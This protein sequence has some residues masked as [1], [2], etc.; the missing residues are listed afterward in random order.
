[1]LL[2][3]VDAAH[4]DRER[5]AAFSFDFDDERYS[6]RPLIEAM[7]AHAGHS[8]TFRTITPDDFVSSLDAIVAQQQE[9]HAGAPITAYT[10]L[11]EQIRSRGAIVAMDG[12]G[13]DEGLAGYARFRPARWADLERAGAHAELAAELAASGVTD[14]DAARAAMAAAA[15]DHGEI[16][17]GQDLTRSVRP[18]CLGAALDGAAPPLPRF[19][20]PFGDAL[21]DLMY[22]ELR[23]TKLPRALRFRDRLSMAYGCELRPPF[24]D[25]RLL[26]YMFALP[27]KDRIYRG[28]TKALLRDAAARALPD[29]VRLAAKRSVQTP[30]REWFRGPLARWLRAQIDRPQFWAR[31]WVDRTKGLSALDGFLAGEGDNSFFVWQWL[32][33]DRW[34]EKFL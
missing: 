1:M 4:P 17:R 27:A 23:Y 32:A 15:S 13:I 11:F 10:L 16:G 19:E 5:I 25:H 33:L 31:G 2:A 6:E 8:V 22:R 3:L 9:P 12:S 20:R 24:L 30:Q 21:R 18:D 7:A 29:A 34:A 28:V 26:A 14:R